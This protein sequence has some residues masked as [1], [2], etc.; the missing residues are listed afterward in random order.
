MASTNNFACKDVRPQYSEED[1]EVDAPVE[2]VE[3]VE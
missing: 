3:Q 1:M 2:Q